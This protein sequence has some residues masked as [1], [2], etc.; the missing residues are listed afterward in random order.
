M[1]SQKSGKIAPDLPPPTELEPGRLSLDRKNPRLAELGI[2][3]NAS[4]PDLIKVLWENMAVA[5]IALSIVENGFFKF[6]PLFA[7]LEGGRHVVIEGN[8]RLAAVKIILDDALREH[9]GAATLPK[10]SP[11]LRAQLNTLPVIVCSREDV[12]QFLGFKHVNGP[13][14][15]ESYAKGQYVAWVR[16]TLDV[17]LS[18][19][20]RRI[21]DE[22]DTVER[23]YRCLMLLEQAEETDVFQ[24]S[25]R[26][27]KHFSFSHLYTGLN[28]KGFQDYLGVD[29]KTPEKKRP[30]PAGKVKN[31]GA[32][33]T[34]LFGS[35]TQNREPLVLSQNPDLRRLDEA[36]QSPGGRRAL[37]Q[38]LPLQVSL[39]IGRGD[40]RVFREALV[41]AKQA[42]QKARGTV[43]TGFDGDTDLLQTA[44][45]IYALG[46]DLV[47]E[48]TEIGVGKKRK[49][50]R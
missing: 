22:H 38:G 19:I 49:G 39:E 46:E 10:A 26:W 11:S 35:K 7:T 15:W 32:L 36:L 28:Y 5:E 14:S 20:A 27:K 45:E 24:R 17:P 34:W 18:E 41:A 12:W 1:A 43:L 50:A 33:C 21:G 8:R 9:V 44:K 3:P 4:E 31:L 48:M 37:E 2:A 6:E 42:L 23:L 30:V 16:N 40:D 47:T 29:N 25:D 13:Q